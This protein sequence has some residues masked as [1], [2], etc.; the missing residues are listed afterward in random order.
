MLFLSGLCPYAGL[1]VIGIARQNGVIDSNS[2]APKYDIIGIF[3]NDGTYTLPL[4][5]KLFL[6][7]YE[8]VVMF[9]YSLENVGHL[10]YRFE[11]LPVDSHCLKDA[12]FPLKHQCLSLRH[13]V[14]FAI[15]IIQ[16]CTETTLQFFHNFHDHYERVL[17]FVHDIDVRTWDAAPFMATISPLTGTCHQDWRGIETSMHVVFNNKR[18]QELRGCGRTLA[19]IGSVK[20][21]RFQITPFDIIEIY[22]GIYSDPD[23]VDDHIIGNASLWFTPAAQAYI[24]NGDQ[25]YALYA[26][27]TIRGLTPSSRGVDIH[28][29]NTWR[30]A[31][32]Y[33]NIV[34][35][36]NDMIEIVSYIKT[37]HETVEVIYTAKGNSSLSYS[38]YAIVSIL[39][40]VRT[41]SSFDIRFNY[42][43]Y[44]DDTLEDGHQIICISVKNHGITS[45][46]LNCDIYVVLILWDYIYMYDSI[47]RQFLNHTQKFYRHFEQHIFAPVTLSASEAEAMCRQQNG[48]LMSIGK[49]HAVL[50]SRLKYSLDVLQFRF[51]IVSAWDE[52]TKN[53]WDAIWKTNCKLIKDI[54]NLLSIEYTDSRQSIY[55][56]NYLSPYVLPVILKL[57]EKLF[58]TNRSKVMKEMTSKDCLLIHTNTKLLLKS[59]AV[60]LVPCDT[61][62]RDVGFGCET[63]VE[64]LNSKRSLI[65]KGRHEHANKTTYEYI[66][67]TG[68]VYECQDM[69]HILHQYV[70]DGHPDCRFGEDEENCSHVCTMTIFTPHKDCFIRCHRYNCTCSPLYYQCEAGGC[71]PLTKICDSYQDCTDNSDEF[72]TLCSIH[73]NDI[74]PIG[75]NKYDWH[76][77][78]RFRFNIDELVSYSPRRDFKV[79]CYHLELT[80]SP[81]E[82]SY[83][84]TVAK[85][86]DKANTR[87]DLYH[88][89]VCDGKW[90]C[91]D[92][93]D[94]WGFNCSQYSLRHGYHCVRDNLLVNPCLIKPIS[95]LH[96]VCPNDGGVYAWCVQ[97]YLP[98]TCQGKMYNLFC[99]GSHVLH[100]AIENNVLT[101]LDILLEHPMTRSIKMIYVFPVS[102]V[103]T[104]NQPLKFQPMVQA[105]QS[106]QKTYHK[107]QQEKYLLILQISHS[108]LVCLYHYQFASLGYLTKLVLINNSIV[109]INP[110]AFSNLTHLSYLSLSVNPVHF[111]HNYT[112]S[113]LTHL[114]YLDLSH[115]AI[116]YLQESTFRYNSH[117]ETLI[118]NHAH[119]QGITSD[120]LNGL[121]NLMV[122]DIAHIS[123]IPRD[124]VDMFRMFKKLSLIYV[125]DFELCCIVNHDVTCVP[126]FPSADVFFS[127]TDI[128]HSHFLMF[129]TYLY[130]AASFSL[131]TLSLI[132]QAY[133]AKAVHS[134][135]LY[136]LNIADSLMPVYLI[137]ILVLHYI[138]SGD[139]AYVALFWK[140]SI[141][142]RAI[143]TI[144]VLS[145][146]ASN[147]ATCLLALDRF[148]C[149]VWKP[150]QRHGFTTVQAIAG[151]CISTMFI[152]ISPL[153]ALFL[154]GKD[155]KNTVCIAIGSSLSLPFSITYVGLN[156][157]SISM[158]SLCCTAIIITVRISSTIPK[159]IDT[160]SAIIVRLMA[161]I[162]T[163][164]LPS[165]TLT[166][167]SVLAL[168]SVNFPA[169]M[170]AYVAFTIFPINASLNPIINTITMRPFVSAFNAHI[171]RPVKSHIVDKTQRIRNTIRMK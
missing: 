12:C 145:I 60:L 76:M 157:I 120:T 63:H 41:R 92:G 170:E 62:L 28:I 150:F 49:L 140:R 100:S 164:L 7:R 24:I 44:C 142:C 71:V 138:H 9:K 64:S 85:C 171:F 135:L 131:N 110:F 82:C 2:I 25:S 109:Y 77:V 155:I 43:H 111:I 19:T 122:I 3:C 159:T 10:S 30:P 168:S 88:H 87:R 113:E 80:P 116:T 144:M 51:W 42:T 1:A 114:M 151:M 32:V 35:Q 152:L 33:L 134:R 107:F 143:G 6:Y 69:T 8:A 124:E 89:E 166:L 137:M 132:W 128:L 153:L 59:Y 160:S 58:C 86:V 66:N 13:G 36:T 126:N 147:A 46:Y 37:E 99:D 96:G 139:V 53:T 74:P 73:L 97:K 22:Y 117:L 115:T 4:S 163:N 15:R 23:C 21:L 50:L 103:T 125:S 156:F 90:D 94:E 93:E 141:L 18:P 79:N 127:C 119:L 83:I 57:N 38:T 123:S 31:I 118:V 61:I 75:M 104:S 162:V 48:S 39:I 95:A 112:F 106:N 167:L 169:T 108:S 45:R 72:A 121:N 16:Y 27:S 136:F 105:C 129:L 148:I 29:T 102:N 14:Q 81:S 11:H 149:I 98:H 54:Y 20:T 56:T 133:T 84:G 65:I 40:N 146:H 52:M 68:V 70:C 78:D 101:L 67:N 26:N 17:H 34:S 130:A 165:M 158:L 91:R 154:S 47:T 55:T 5:Q 161:I